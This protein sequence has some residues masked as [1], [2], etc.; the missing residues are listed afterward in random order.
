MEHKQNHSNH[1][2]HV[3]IH[4][5]SNQRKE[6]VKFAG[7]M[8]VIVVLSY[9]HA[10]WIGMHLMQFLESFMGVFFVVFAGFKI[11]QLKEFAYGFQSY[12]LVA[13][14]SLLYSYCYPFIQLLFGLI[15]LLGFATIAVDIV[16]LVVSLLSGLGVL[17]SLYKK[18]QVHCVCLGNVIKLPL[19][20]ISFVEDFGM[21]IMA[22]AMI[23]MR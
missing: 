20:T 23:I 17:N 10:T 3:M 9:V 15:Y 22:L 7:I 21:A 12:D 19:S 11:M 4:E 2:E 16:V 14:R 13:K 6:Y 5:S 18:Q 8:S 1:G